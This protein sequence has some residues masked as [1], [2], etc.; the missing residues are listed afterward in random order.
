MKG[1]IALKYSEIKTLTDFK[2]YN[3]EKSKRYY[4]K[5]RE[6]V[7]ARNKANYR[8]KIEE[9]RLAEEIL[10]QNKQEVKS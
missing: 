4:E 8:K 1:E 7:I 3:R 5:N 9:L 2:Q 6:R 10:N